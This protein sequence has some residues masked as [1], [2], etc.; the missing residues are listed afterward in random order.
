[1][2]G[3]LGLFSQPARYLVRSKSPVRPDPEG[4][5][6]ALPDQLVNRGLVDSQ[7]LADFLHRQD[8]MIECHRALLLKIGDDHPLHEGDSRAAKPT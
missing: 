1:M 4:W 8:F 6:P 7:Y 3:A 2:R 5:N